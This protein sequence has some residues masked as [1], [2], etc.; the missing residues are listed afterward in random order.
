M[1]VHIGLLKTLLTFL[2][3]IVVGFFWR[4]AAFNWSDTYFGQAMAFIY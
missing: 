3:V 4:L 1:H 2:D